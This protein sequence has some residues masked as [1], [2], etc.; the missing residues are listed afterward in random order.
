[1]V[2]LMIEGEKATLSEDIAADITYSLA[3]IR[4]PDK[5]QVNYTKTITLEGTAN[6]NYIFGNIFDIDVENPINTTNFPNVGVYYTAKKLAKAALYADGVQIF[7]GTLRLWKIE[8]KT[9]IIYYQISLFGK[10]FDIF[11]ILGDD[12]LTD[13]DFSNFNHAVTWPNIMQTWNTTGLGWNGGYVYPLIDY[14]QNGDSTGRITSIKFGTLS[15]NIRYK[16]FVDKIFT[17]AGALYTLNFTD[18][19]IYD[20]MI[21]TPPYGLATSRPNY[22]RSQKLISTDTFFPQSAFAPTLY[23]RAPI[24][25]SIQSNV[26]FNVITGSANGHLQ[27]TL[28]FNQNVATSIRFSMTA[29]AVLPSSYGNRSHSIKLGHWSATTGTQSEL[30]SFDLKTLPS[31]SNT[32]NI[33]FD[34]PKRSWGVNDEIFLLLVVTQGST[35]IIHNNT[36]VEAISATDTEEYPMLPGDIYDMNRSVPL[37]IKQVDFIKDFIKLF[38]LYVTQDPENPNH[39]IFTPQSNFY[40]NEK[41][42]AIDWTRKIDHDESITYTPISQLSAKQ[43]LFTW[44]AD[45]DYWNDLYLT[46]NKEVYGQVTYIADTDVVTN[47]EKVEFI[48]SPAVMT[49]FVNS[50][51]ICPA[52]YK[53]ETVA[54]VQVR[55]ADKFNSRLLIWGELI[56]AGHNID[57]LNPDGSVAFGTTGYPYAGHLDNPQSP[58]FDLN[59]GNTNTNLPTATK[60]QFS[61]YWGKGLKESNHKDAKLMAC[62][63][64]VKPEDVEN[65]DFAALYKVEDQFFRLNKISG[66]N[67]FN[68]DTSSVELIKVL[69]L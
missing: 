43:Y 6:N 1:M 61:E 17:N 65:L 2:E 57:L 41:A 39:Y 28:K 48:F 10:L 38:N 42:D 45:K 8:K 11:S 29:T 68:L 15:P 27:Q 5:R 53:M 12:K 31:A 46:Q 55:K 18:R 34:I 16:V 47:T 20:K 40:K 25:D 59:F 66:F 33:V 3:D 64:L 22:F 62:S 51:I 36:F 63:M 7:D 19:S 24:F 37:E 23:M 4:T 60:N 44:K 32:E 58:T 69:N 67:P 52:I 9:G 13:L 54:G 56:P 49:R 26:I 35:L 30:A 21:V 50:L 14:G